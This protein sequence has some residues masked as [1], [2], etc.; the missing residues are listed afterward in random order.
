[1]DLG[2]SASRWSAEAHFRVGEFST[3]TMGNFRLELTGVQN[4]V[5]WRLVCDWDGARVKF[6]RRLMVRSMLT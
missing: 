1:M 3:G 4:S 2:L 6:T 5:F